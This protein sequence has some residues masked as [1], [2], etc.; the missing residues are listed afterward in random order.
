MSEV[1]KSRWEIKAEATE[2]LNTARTLVEIAQRMAEENDIT[3]M[4]IS[5][6][7]SYGTTTLTWYNS[8]ESC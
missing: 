6:G 8:S 7:K 2:M 3:E 1:K 5:S 4:D